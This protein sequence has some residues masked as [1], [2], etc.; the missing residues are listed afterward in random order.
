M[1][2]YRVTTAQH[3]DAAN[4]EGAMVAQWFR[5]KQSAIK[6]Y[7]ESVRE[8]ESDRKSDAGEFQFHFATLEEVEVVVRSA[9]SLP[10]D[11]LA[12]LNQRGFISGSVVIREWKPDHRSKP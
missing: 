8:Q 12:V 2:F 4:P 5:S 6:A 7:T 3:E 9:K 1:K 10:K 11:L